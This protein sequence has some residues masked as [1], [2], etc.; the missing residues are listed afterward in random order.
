MWQILHAQNIYVNQNEFLSRGG[1]SSH[2]KNVRDDWWAAYMKGFQIW[3]G[4]VVR[5]KKKMG[6]EIWRW[7]SGP[8]PTRNC[9]CD[10]MQA[11]NS[12]EAVSP[13]VWDKGNN[14]HLILNIRLLCPGWC[15]SVDWVSVCKPKSGP[16]LILSQDTCLGC[17]PVGG[18][19]EATPWCFSTSLSP[20][21]PPP[22]NK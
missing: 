7:V 5:S 19:Q 2:N 15:G 20:S 4:M 1:S 8:S 13:H 3:E 12:S 10:V 18:A 17:R 16:A 11:R 21:L 9:V 14:L 22:K 6:L